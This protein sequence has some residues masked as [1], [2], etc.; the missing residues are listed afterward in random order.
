MLRTALPS[1]KA[2]KDT[3]ATA[4]KSS[5]HDTAESKTA[6]RKPQN[7]KAPQLFVDTDTSDNHD[8]TNKKKAAKTR[9]ITKQ[10]KTRTTSALSPT[11]NTPKAKRMIP[12]FARPTKSS[13]AKQ[14][15]KTTPSSPSPRA[16]TRGRTT[17]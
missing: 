10:S 2:T 4:D 12:S 17:T 9:Q 1:H 8:H 13:Q 5:P 3:G 16:S 7:A 6:V 11:G 14:T 15:S